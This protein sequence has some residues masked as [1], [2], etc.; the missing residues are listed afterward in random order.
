MEF[1]SARVLSNDV[2]RLAGFYEQATGLEARRPAEQFAEFA[3]ASGKLAIGS[4]A[5]MPQ[6]ATAGPKTPEPKTPEPKTPEPKTP[7]PKTPEPKTPEPKTTGPDP[8]TILEFLVEDVDRAYERLMRLAVVPEIVQGPTTMP[9]GN[10]SLLFRD[11]EGN[12]VNFFAPVTED[13]RARLA[14]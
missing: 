2:A 13:A 9:W 3:G 4:T 12:L 6:S 5:T 14:R 10:R 7:E 1:V 11:P 8:V